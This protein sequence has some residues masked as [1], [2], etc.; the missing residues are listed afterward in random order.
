MV[1]NFQELGTFEGPPTI[2]GGKAILKRYVF[3]FLRKEARLSQD[4]N[5]VRS[6][7]QMSGAAKE[8]AQF[9]FS[10]GD[11]KLLRGR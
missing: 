1:N 6:M 2:R 4:F 11:I 9:Q 10:S 3:R 8:N 7:F 5:V